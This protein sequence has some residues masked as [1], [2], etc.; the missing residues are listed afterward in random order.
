MKKLEDY[1]I[2]EL[3]ELGED[4]DNYYILER[5]CCEH[6]VTVPCEMQL[7]NDQPNY[8]ADVA[9]MAEALVDVKEDMMRKPGRYHELF[10]DE[11][12]QHHAPKCC[13][14]SCWCKEE[15]EKPK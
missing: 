7:V 13:S 15:Y 8:V 5:L 6:L 3:R 2:W 12:H 1:K 10:C 4:P 9:D 14:A 11:Y